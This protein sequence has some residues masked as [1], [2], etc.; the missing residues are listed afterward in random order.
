ML[1][2][3]LLES[4]LVL[5]EKTNTM[6]SL[7]VLNSNVLLFFCTQI[8]HFQPGTFLELNYNSKDEY[9]ITENTFFTPYFC[10]DFP[11]NHLLNDFEMI[12]QHIGFLLEKAVD[13]RVI[14]DRPIGCL[15]S[16]GLDSSLVT[17]LVNKHFEEGKLNTFS[18][19]MKG[20]TDLFYA[21]KV[22][23]H[24]K[25]NHHHIELTET[26]FLDAIDHVIFVIESYDTT[27][28]R[29]SV[30][31]YLV[32]KYIKENTDIKVVFNGDGSEEIFGSYLYF[33][34]APTPQDFYQENKKLINE[35]FYFDVLR[36][37]KSISSNGL[38]PR[39]PF[40]DT[41][42]VSFVMSI[43]PEYK[44]HGLS[45]P[46]KMEKYILRKAFES[47]DLLPLEV[48]WRKKEAFSDGVSSKEKSWYNTIQEYVNNLIS[49]QE[50]EQY[51]NT[52]I[53]LPPQLKETFYYRRVF[54]KHFGDR[55]S[56]ILPHYWLPNWS[57]DVIDPSA[58]MLT[59]YE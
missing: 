28:V 17:A 35:I 49:D 10:K 12:I 58:R 15:L 40:L 25:T 5:L 3:I 46:F 52:Y 23:H 48:L 22:S 1:P 56:F 11:I 38:E 31:N 30:G 2:E 57:G 37:D 54:E 13:K 4:V 33:Q 24:C 18:I 27:T 55:H 7:F 42:L 44:M 51:K 21:Q 53:H 20:S 36:S 6:K 59:I 41:E 26:N 47:T 32:S 50:F 8:V 14:A 43:P 19:G 39:T 16:G 29:A 9:C 34:N 45:S